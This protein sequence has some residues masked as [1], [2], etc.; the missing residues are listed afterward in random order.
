MTSKALSLS[1]LD[2]VPVAVGSDT[3]TALRNTIDLAR[4]ADGLGF[5]RYWIAERHGREASTGSAPDVIVSHV[6]TQTVQIR[7]GV[8][9]IFLPDHNVTSVVETFRVLNALHP[10]RVDLGIDRSNVLEDIRRSGLGASSVDRDSAAVPA[11]LEQLLAIFKGNVLADDSP[12]RAVLVPK[13]GEPPIWL[14]GF[15]VESARLAARCGIGFVYAH[16]LEPV[17]VGRALQVYRSEFRRSSSFATP[18]AFIAA[19]VICAETDSRASEL[20][21]TMAL[22]WLQIEEG[23]EM[24]FPSVEMAAQFPYTGEERRKIDAIQQ[25]MFV[26]S[27]S[28][29]VKRLTALATECEVA[30]IMILTV[31]HDHP[32]R[33]QSY[34]LLAEACARQSA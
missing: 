16:Y 1:V 3:A 22:E 5:T 27:A 15:D 25:R 31:T 10:G 24:L 17:D 34:Q 28:N 32:A 12:G 8:G 11:E 33:R 13:S 19:V 23:R 21:S 29:L 2:I 30:E 9:G 4:L 20:A 6:A 7:V 26:G 14:I 18:H